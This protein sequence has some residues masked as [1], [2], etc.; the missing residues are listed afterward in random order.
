VWGPRSSTLA[1]TT[2]A[3]ALGREVVEVA[4][5]KRDKAKQTPTVSICSHPTYR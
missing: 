1:S 4:S 2:T 5:S 3:L